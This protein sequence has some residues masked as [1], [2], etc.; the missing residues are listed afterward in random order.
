M[1]EIALNNEYE[2]DHSLDDLFVP[3]KIDEEESEH[4]SAE[5]YSYWKSVFRVFI[6]KPA[7]I[8][9]II[10]FIILIIGIVVIPRFASATDFEGGVDFVNAA[11]SA[12]H[13]WGCDSK[14]RDLFFITW[15]GAGSSLGLALISSAIVTVLGVIFGLTWGY[16]KKIDW[17]FV[18]LYNLVVNIPSLLVYMLLSTIFSHSLP[19]ISPEGRLIFSLCITGWLGL[20]YMIRNQ[21]LIIDNREYN[22]ASKTLAT[23]ASRIMFKN[24]L[25]FILGI[26]ITDFSLIVPGMISSEVSM[27]YFGVGLP[28]DRIAIGA[29]LEL[30][31][32]EFQQRPWQVL[33]PGLLMAIIIF[34][35][36]LFGMALSDALDPKKHR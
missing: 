2:L 13:I 11:P 20:A 23:P 17:F 8:I 16:L 4:L 12:N 22:V 36:F 34:I 6:H 10:T 28:K 7:A 24:Y 5:P 27:S 14:G 9:S 1:S 33:A 19:W 31:T 3:V 30:G 26:I 18:E 35:F 15:S 29:I 25:P 21:V 32:K